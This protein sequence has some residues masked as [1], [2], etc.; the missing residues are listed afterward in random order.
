MRRSRGQRRDLPRMRGCPDGAPGPRTD[1]RRW[2]RPNRGA[3][4]EFATAHRMARASPAGPLRSNGRLTGD[5]K[6]TVPRQRRARVRRPRH[7]RLPVLWHLAETTTFRSSGWSTDPLDRFGPDVSSVKALARGPPGHGGPLLTS[8]PVAFPAIA[9][10]SA[11]TAAPK[12]P[13]GFPAVFPAGRR[14][15]ASSGGRRTGRPRSR[16]VRRRRFPLPGASAGS[17]TSTV[18]PA[19]ST[20]T[21]ARPPIAAA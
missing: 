8:R 7:G 16:R 6:D 15:Q 17:I 3:L 5:G 19:T 4:F 20:V 21:R 1:P 2:C 11:V 9:Q 18:R 10:V 13:M 12:V 14:R